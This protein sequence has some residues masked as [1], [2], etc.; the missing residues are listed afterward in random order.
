M[1]SLDTEVAIVG[2]GVLGCAVLH[3]LT[4]RGVSATLL[5]AEAGL[6]LG[7][8]GANSGILHTGFDS[9]PGALETRM[10]I[11][12][13]VLREQLL[14]ELALE[15]RR[16]GAQM[17]PVDDAGRA[18]VADLARN[19]GQNGVEVHLSAEHVLDIPGESLVDPVAYTQALAE[20]ARSAGAAVVLDAP[21]AGLRVEGDGAVILVEVAGGVPVRAGAVVNCAGLYADR[22]ARLAGDASFAIYPRKGEFLV[23]RMPGEAALEQIL[24]PVPSKLGK[25]VLVFPTL[26]GE[27]VAGPT[28]RD[29]TDK[30]DWSVEPDA[31]EI[32]L[33]RLGTSYPPLATAEQIG[34]YAGL[35][36]AGAGLNYLIEFSQRMRRLL[37]VAAIRSTGLS[38]SLGIGEHVVELLSRA[39]AIRPLA[40]RVLPAPAGALAAAGEQAPWWIRGQRHR[41]THRPDGA[42]AG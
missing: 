25:G 34:S 18:Q 8:S 42:G 2:G 9:P 19:A 39:G 5:E 15:V 11:R 36:P 40:A 35:R 30:E 41:Q 26:A 16:C 4:R 22:I 17:R 28:A 33:S 10:I 24:L 29:R 32:I 3:A 20:A 1:S 38:A 37:H 21:V 23:F 13:G 27:L 6:A 31:A 7:A 12:S 14:D